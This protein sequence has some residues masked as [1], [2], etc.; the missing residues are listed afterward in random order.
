MILKKPL[1]MRRNGIENCD[2]NMKTESL[3]QLEGNVYN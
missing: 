2:K 1:A 3:I